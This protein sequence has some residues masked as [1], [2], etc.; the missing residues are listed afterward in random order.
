MLVI[1]N[2]LLLCSI[3][4]FIQNA[5]IYDNLIRAHVNA[6]WQN[7]CSCKGVAPSFDTWHHWQSDA[8]GFK[9]LVGGVGGRGSECAAIYV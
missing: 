6:C 7:I 8:R 1:N 5:A 9:L 4:C 2:S 3:P